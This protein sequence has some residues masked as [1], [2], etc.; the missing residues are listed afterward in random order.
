MSG[1]VELC[2]APGVGK[3]TLAR[4]LTGHLALDVNGPSRSSAPVIVGAEHLP[5]ELRAP[6]ARIAQIARIARTIPIGARSSGPRRLAHLTRWPLTARMLRTSAGDLSRPDGRDPSRS[7][8]TSPDVATVIA[9]LPAPAGDDPRAS[10]GYRAQAL[11]WLGLMLRLTDLSDDLPGDV[12]AV[13]SE[14]TVQRAVSLLGAQADRDSVAE[15][16][17]RLPTPRAVVHLHADVGLLEG[18]ASLRRTTG[19]SPSLHEGL[20]ADTALAAIVDDARA[21]AVAVAVQAERGVP[22]LHLEADAASTPRQL[23][24]EVLGFLAR[25]AV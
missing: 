12:I 10:D 19:G 17:S 4:A 23:A 15:L 14:G 22:V 20:D 16:A 9:G 3:T 21:I 1:F 11:Q 25:S 13:L 7:R 18:R 5:L 2:G 6:F 8:P 24:D